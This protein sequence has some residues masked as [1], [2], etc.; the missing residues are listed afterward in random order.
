VTLPLADMNGVSLM[1]G[2]VEGKHL[3]LRGEITF[4][5]VGQWI[6]KNISKPPNPSTFQLVTK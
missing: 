4:T 6:F 5:V 3:T 2:I 1:S